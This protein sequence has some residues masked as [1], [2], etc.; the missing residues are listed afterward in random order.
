MVVRGQLLT[1]GHVGSRASPHITSCVVL[2]KSTQC[3]SFLI[4]KMEVKLVINSY[5]PSYTRIMYIRQLARYLATGDILVLLLIILSIAA[6]KTFVLHPRYARHYWDVT[7]CP[8]GGSFPRGS[9]FYENWPSDRVKGVSSH[10]IQKGKVTG[11]GRNITIM[12]NTCCGP[13][14]LLTTSI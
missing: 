11:T 5:A 7:H 10:K 13:V 8:Q 9:S 12:L 3:L 4:C 14:P 6:S 2:S 1:S